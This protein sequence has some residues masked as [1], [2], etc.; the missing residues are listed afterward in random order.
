MQPSTD[1][2]QREPIAVSLTHYCVMGDVTI[3]DSAAI[4]PGVVLQASAGSRIVVGKGVCLA[5]GVCIQSRAGV[6]TILNGVSLGANVLVIGKG[7]I[8]ANACVSPG[9]TLINPTIETGAILP[10]ATL[11]GGKPASQT[12]DK[13]A[14][15][16]GGNGYSQPSP[17]PQ[18]V[19]SQ[20]TFQNT[21]VEPG[22]IT[23]QPVSIPDLSDQSSAFVPPPPINQPFN[24]PFNQ[25]N[26]HVSNHANNGIPT[27]GVQSGYGSSSLTVQTSSNHVYGKSQVSELIST[28]FPHRQPLNSQNDNSSS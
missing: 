9:S 22:P 3:D 15:S 20:S 13:P 4:A 1:I 2:I 24:Q 27:N 7:T 16:F 11:L 14:A 12:K 28:L 19:G 5:A 26:G 17:N 25:N 8:G 21:F 18:P 10:P 23:A 6:L